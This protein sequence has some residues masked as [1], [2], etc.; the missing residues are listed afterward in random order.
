MDVNDFWDDNED[1]ESIR[2][3]IRNAQPEHGCHDCR[4]SK[5]YDCAQGRPAY[6]NGGPDQCKPQ[7]KA[8]GWRPR[9][10]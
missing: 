6:P 9:V 3:S 5:M 7:K 1:Y 10:P 4:S 8:P 2:N